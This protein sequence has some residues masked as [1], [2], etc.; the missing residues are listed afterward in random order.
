MRTRQRCGTAARRAWRAAPRADHVALLDRER[1]P[2]P[3]RRAGPAARWRRRCGC[4]GGT[5]T[6]RSTGQSTSIER[7]KRLTRSP[8][9]P[10]LGAA[11][12]RRT[13]SSASC[14]VAPATSQAVKPGCARASIGGADDVAPAQRASAR[15]VEDVARAGQRRRVRRARRSGCRPSRGRGSGRGRRPPAARR[16]ARQA[17]RRRAAT[18]SAPDATSTSSAPPGGSGPARRRGR[19]RRESHRSAAAASSASAISGRSPSCAR[20]RSAVDAVGEGTRRPARGRPGRRAGAARRCATDPG[21]AGPRG[22][23]RSPAPLAPGAGRVGL[24]AARRSSRARTSRGRGPASARARAGR[25]PAARRPP[26]RRDGDRQRVLV[27]RQDGR[28]VRRARVGEHGSAARPAGP[29][30]EA[31]KATTSKVMRHLRP[32]AGRRRERPEEALRRARRRQHARRRRGG[33]RHL[34]R[35]GQAVVAE[36]DRQ[37]GRRQARQVRVA[38]ER[39]PVVPR[40]RRSARRRCCAGLG[41]PVPERLAAERRRRAGRARRC[42]RGGRR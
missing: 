32:V 27:D 22:G 20:R 41:A 16:R 3:A 37:R 30:L 29:T 2:R 11:V 34:Q 42:A 17:T 26:P 23:S 6:A 15:T 35:H 24:P 40:R 39:A 38:Q 13:V 14:I 18:P 31:A 7:S 21:P 1:R 5:R 9:R 4:R 19:R 36:A 25:P 12:M 28:A 33:A 10:A 8:S